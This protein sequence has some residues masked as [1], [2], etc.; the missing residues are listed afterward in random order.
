[1]L[2][3]ASKATFSKM[4]PRIQPL[5]M[6]NYSEKPIVLSIIVS[7]SKPQDDSRSL[8]RH[9][10]NPKDGFLCCITY[11][12]QIELQMF[13]ALWQILNKMQGAFI[14]LSRL[15][16]GFSDLSKF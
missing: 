13:V 1:M 10:L 8:R 14:R 16:V 7:E 12:C 3:T 4:I 11:S 5:G 6:N 2:K 15:E 9:N